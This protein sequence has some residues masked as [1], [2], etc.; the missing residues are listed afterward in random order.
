MEQEKNE[1]YVITE[2]LLAGEAEY[3]MGERNSEIA[4]FVTW[5]CR[6]NETGKK[7][8]FWG[9]YFND[10]LSSVEDLCKRTL[11]EIHYIKSMQEAVRQNENKEITENTEKFFDGL[12][13]YCYSILP[14]TYQCIIIER[15]AKGYTKTNIGHTTQEEVDRM[16]GE[17]GVTKAQAR[18][19]EEGLTFGWKTPEANPKLYDENGESKKHRVE[20]ER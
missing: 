4:Q 11:E 15:G 1:G 5:K 14:I 9:H 2:S 18:A 10:R 8:Y 13:E 7:D 12:P 20:Q 3:V 17:I 6:T 19:M 16:N